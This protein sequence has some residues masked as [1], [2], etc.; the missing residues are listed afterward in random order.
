MQNLLYAGVVGGGDGLAG[1][2]TLAERVGQVAAVCDGRQ[3]GVANVDLMPAA[4][5]S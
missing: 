2:I 4:E 5:A 1:Q 3:G